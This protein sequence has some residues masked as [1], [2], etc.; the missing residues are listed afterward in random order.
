MSLPPLRLKKDQERRL[1]TG[2][3]W[4][5]S[6]EIDTE[7]TPLPAFEPGVAVEVW[8]HGGTWLG[9]A[10][11]NPH[12]LIAG[13][14]VS[15]HRSRPPSPALWGE[16]IRSALELRQRLYRQPYYRLVFGEADGLPGLTVDRYGEVL[17]VQLTTAGME[18]V[19]AE[20]ITA[21]EQVVRPEAVL[22]RNDASV[23]ALEGLPS[24]VETLLG[25]LPETLTLEEGGLRFRVPLKEGQKTGW[26]FDQAENRARLQRYRLHG[27]VLD[28]FSYLGAWGVQAAARG[29]HE[30][31][32]LD[33]SVAALEGVLHNAG[34]NGL[35]GRVQTL[36]GDAFATLKGLAEAGERFD[37][38]I[39]DPPAFIKRR[40]DLTEGTEAYH[41]LN[42]LGLG[43]LN[44]G[45]LLVSAS[46]S[47]H[48][49]RDAFLRTVQ[50]GSRRTGL[51]LQLL[52]VGG[53]GPDHPVHPA[54]PETA[55]LK[56]LFFRAVPS[57]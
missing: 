57:F 34:L 28:A 22:L 27:R 13:R 48:L 10:Q 31:L 38:V 52:E 49:D 20:L 26:F 3:C 33:A 35:T 8:S 47:F 1:L 44:P 5:Y 15:R 9:Y 30:V 19:R 2:H 12:S 17:V 39:L 25:A 36:Q 54:I 11:V 6:N 50:R 46:C 32:C 40:R 51:S 24:Y 7:A 56:T 29:A 55:Y 53:Q 18:R 14:L 16:R 45:G 41:R 23:R 4:I 42:R 37:T 21:L 43:L